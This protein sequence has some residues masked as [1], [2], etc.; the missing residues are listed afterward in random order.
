MSPNDSLSIKDFADLFGFSEDSIRQA[1]AAQRYRIAKNQAYYSIPD[2]AA[3]WC[4]SVPQTYKLLRDASAKIVNV[5][6][7]TKR[8]KILIPASV[9][10][11]IEKSRTEKMS[12]VTTT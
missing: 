9:V 5:G 2:L 6:E 10:A 3:R 11:Q 4:V 8:K 12:G 1:V 7:G